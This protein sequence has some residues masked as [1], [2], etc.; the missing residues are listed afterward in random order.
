[1]DPHATSATRHAAARLRAA[2]EGLWTSSTG[3]SRPQPASALQCVPSCLFLAHHPSTPPGFT[4]AMGWMFH[5]RDDRYPWHP[6]AW[7]DLPNR[8][9]LDLTA[10]QFGYDPILLTPPEDVRTLPPVLAR[11]WES[12]RF[13]HDPHHPIPYTRYVRP[14]TPI[15]PPLDGVIQAAAWAAEL[16]DH[17]D[18]PSVAQALQ[19]LGTA[20]SAPIGPR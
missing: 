17:P 15:L 8:W 20:T 9:V 5:P 18:S 2:L 4:F 7:I 16:H 1:M 10:D 3:P 19:D 13:D 11:G 12:G 14:P 6:H